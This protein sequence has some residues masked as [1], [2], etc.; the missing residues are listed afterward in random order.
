MYILYIWYTGV[1]NSLVVLVMA[2][3][4]FCEKNVLWSLRDS[5]HH[6]EWC[7]YVLRLK[8]R[9]HAIFDLRYFAWT[10]FPRA[11]GILFPISTISSFSENS[12]R[13]SQLKVRHRINDTGSKFTTGVVDWRQI[14]RWCQ[15]QRWW[16]I[17]HRCQRPWRKFSD[18]V[19][20]QRHRWSAKASVAVCLHLKL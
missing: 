4:N 11:L 15:W 1:L 2:F 9:W 5:D 3:N 17:C 6:P 10:I 8:G 7:D 14:Y 16:Q 20:C 18:S 13:Y 19:N 12:R